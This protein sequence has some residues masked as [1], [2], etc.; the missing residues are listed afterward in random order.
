MAI[1]SLRRECSTI[2]EH[3]HP[4]F[5]FNLSAQAFFRYAFFDY[6]AA[7]DYTLPQMIRSELSLG[8]KVVQ[9]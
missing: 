8:S 4:V 1:N 2:T 7:L 6:E 3:N 5:D 9:L